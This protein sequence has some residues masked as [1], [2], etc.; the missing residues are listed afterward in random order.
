MC[1]PWKLLIKPC[2]RITNV[3]LKTFY[4]FDA[5]SVQPPCNLKIAVLPG[6]VR[7]TCLCACPVEKEGGKRRW[8]QRSCGTWPDVSGVVRGLGSMAAEVSHALGRD[9]GGPGQLADFSY[10]Q[11][12]LHFQSSIAQMAE[13]QANPIVQASRCVCLTCRHAQDCLRG[14]GVVCCGGVG[15]LAQHFTG[16]TEDARV[17]LWSATTPPWVVGRAMSGVL[18]LARLG[19]IPSMAADE[20]SQ[21]VDFASSQAC[22]GCSSSTS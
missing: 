16:P 18:A 2:L 11:L 17:A 9:R 6:G 10:S 12:A 14:R 7:Q 4:V 19:L 5:E 3:N 15:W 1:T 13:R 22:E 8:A 21:A 20:L